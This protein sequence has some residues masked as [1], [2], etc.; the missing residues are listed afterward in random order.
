MSLLGGDKDGSNGPPEHGGE[1]CGRVVGG[2]A[3]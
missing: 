1:S 3:V 2:M